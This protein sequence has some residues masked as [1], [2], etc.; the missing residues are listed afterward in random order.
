MTLHATP[1]RHILADFH[2]VSASLLGDAQALERELLRAAEAAGAR[3]LGTHFHHFGAGAGVTGVVMLSESHISVH[4]WPEHQFAA[5]DI[6]M[7]GAA[8]P[9]LALECLRAALGPDSARVTT[10]E[11]G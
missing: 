6:F 5:L 1:G 7:C 3:V 4:S 10:V 8:R 2:G 11:R 9:E